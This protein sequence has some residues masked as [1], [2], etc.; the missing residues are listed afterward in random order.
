MGTAIAGI[1]LGL[2]E[3][4]FGRK[5]FWVLVAIGGFLLGWFL[6][7]AVWET[8]VL[9][10]RVLIGLLVA[11]VFALLS[12][13]FV[14]VMVTVAGFFA[15]GAAA[16]MLVRYLGA[17]AAAGSVAFWLAYVIGGLVGAA[18]LFLY[19]DWALIVLTSLGGA[20][21]AAGG[22]IHVAGG[23]PYWV[24]WVLFV[25]LAVVGIGVQARM[26]KARSYSGRRRLVR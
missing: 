3:L 13:L 24:E 20:A 17:E 5:L 22:I 26:F 8:V 15:F 6:V 9:W 1:I 7:P 10:E 14:R 11:V 18:L 21:A 16:V 2:F 25:V 4:L 19:L 12:L 23:G